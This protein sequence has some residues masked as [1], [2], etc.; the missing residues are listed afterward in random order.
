MSRYDERRRQKRGP[1]PGG[2][3]AALGTHPH[4]RKSP[5]RTLGARGHRRVPASNGTHSAQEAPVY[6]SLDDAVRRGAV[7]VVDGVVL[8]TGDGRP[9]GLANGR[10]GRF[11]L[12]APDEAGGSP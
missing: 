6:A 1:D 10:Q 7:Y 8:R 3:N 12:D 9:L 11:S 4:R 5:R 2:G